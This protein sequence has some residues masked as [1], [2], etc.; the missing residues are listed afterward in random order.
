MDLQKNFEK[1]AELLLKKG[2]NIKSGECFTL[3][4]Q[5]E[6]LPLARV[7]ARQAYKMGVKDIIFLFSDDDMTLSRYLYANDA[8]FEEFSK[9]KADYAEA[10]LKAGYH[11]L[12][13]RAAN[14]ELLKNVDSKRLDTWEAVS[15][16]ANKHLRKYT[17]NN[18]VK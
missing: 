15:A 3:S 6:T 1:Y 7:I 5:E 10:Y 17:M 4:V 8:A 9:F 12:A 2:L 14:P 11:R 16:K 13:L 18:M